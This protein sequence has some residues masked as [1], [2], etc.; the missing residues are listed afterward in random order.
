MSCAG[1]DQGDQARQ[2]WGAAEGDGCDAVSHTARPRAPE[3]VHEEPERPR[4]LPP[5]SQVC[6]PLLRT[7]LAK[8]SKN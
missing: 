5:S 1:F 4:A 7:S 2:P 8:K 3:A 6:S